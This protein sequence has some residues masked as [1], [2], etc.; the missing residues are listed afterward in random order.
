MGDKINIKWDTSEQLTLDELVP[1]Q[2]NLKKRTQEDID[3]LK[4]SL[5]REG[6]IMPFAVWKH[7]GR[8]YILDG[9]GRHEALRQLTMD[10]ESGL[11]VTDKYP[12]LIIHADT[13]DDA[14]KTL[15]QITSQYGKITKAGVKQFTAS[16]PT[17]VAPSIQKFVTTGTAKLKP[18]KPVSHVESDKR[19]IKIQVAAADYD[20][21]V[22]ILSKSPYVKIV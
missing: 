3:K 1:F 11:Q 2:G 4:E 17:Y 5:L 19:I 21:V 15:L 22:Q 20:A 12:C 18:V 10:I 14:R 13:E 16:I 8:N 7:D 9:H 6:L